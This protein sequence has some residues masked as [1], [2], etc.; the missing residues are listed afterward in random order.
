MSKRSNTLL[1]GVCSFAILCSIYGY[2]RAAGEHEQSGCGWEGLGVLVLKLMLPDDRDVL[3]G[4]SSVRRRAH[5]NMGKRKK[6]F[7]IKDE[8]F[9]TSDSRTLR[10]YRISQCDSSK[11]RKRGAILIAHGNAMLAFQAL[12]F[13]YELANLGVD[14]IVYDYR[15]YGRSEGSSRLKAIALDYKELSASLRKRYEILLG[16]GASLGGLLL[17]RAQNELNTFDHLILDAPPERITQL[18]CPKVFDPINNVPDNAS[19]LTLIHGGKDKIV[20]VGRLPSLFRK[21][22]ARVVYEESLAHPF[23]DRGANRQ[24]RT[25]IIYGALRGALIDEGFGELVR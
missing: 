19:N 13:G 25:A 2:A 20:R 17:L 4:K 7:Q 16:Y 11:S 15:G 9:L 18:E 22:G 12:P 3:R 23:M 6:C 8:S 24:R 14:I 10:G 5:T 1:G 21:N